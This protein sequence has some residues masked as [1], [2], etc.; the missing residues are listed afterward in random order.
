[1]SKTPKIRA[2]REKEPDFISKTELAHH[3]QCHMGSIDDWIVDGTI[4]PP[5]AR[6]GIKHPIWLRK[7]YNKFRE[8]GEWPKEAFQKP[9]ANPAP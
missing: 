1:M 2:I 6:P 9:K 4:P 8:T 5:Y 3:Y 7:H